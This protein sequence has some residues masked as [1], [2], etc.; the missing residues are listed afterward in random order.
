MI[1]PLKVTGEFP[2]FVQVA[3]DAIVTSPAKS[4]VADELLMTR[5]PLVPPPIVEVPATVKENPD[6]LRLHPSPID[7]LPPIDIVATVVMEAVPPNIRL[8]PTEA[9]DAV[10]VFTPLPER[11]R[12]L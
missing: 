1:P 3:P 12:L 11:I 6:T 9:V 5:L 2:E 7:R 8:P 10:K 4:G